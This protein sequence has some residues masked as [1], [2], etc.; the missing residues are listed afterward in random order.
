MLR[1]IVNKEWAELMQQLGTQGR[2]DQ[3]THFPEA[4]AWIAQ[5]LEKY[6]DQIGWWT[7]LVVHRAD[8][9]LIG[10]GGFKGPVS[11]EGS[12]EI[13]YEIAPEYQGHGLAT[14]LAGALTTEA[15]A[16]TGVKAVL[17]H[18]LA[19]EN[20]SVSVLRK[21]G[22]EQVGER[23]DIEDGHIWQWQLEKP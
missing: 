7:F 11:S 20:A 13:G 23:Y 5:H 6:P 8:N 15:F 21:L 22:F 18:T 10:T 14:E 2:A 1:L 12:L 4:I 9:R 3:W 16:H 19:Q 17:A